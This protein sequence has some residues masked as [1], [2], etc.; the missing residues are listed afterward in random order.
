MM[1]ILYMILDTYA[2]VSFI[3]SEEK[4][5]FRFYIE[6]PYNVQKE[7]LSFKLSSWSQQ[8]VNAQAL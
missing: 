7:L 2:N 5:K 4:S 6:L 8:R 1:Y 3:Q